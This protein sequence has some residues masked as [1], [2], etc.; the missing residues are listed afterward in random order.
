MSRLRHIDL[1]EFGISILLAAAVLFTAAMVML[2]RNV[3]QLSESYGWVE[4]SNDILQGIS[5]VELSIAGVEMTVRGY[6][7]TSNDM[8][9]RMHRLNHTKLLRVTKT[10]GDLVA[11]EP[12]LQPDF[13]TLRG[14]VDQHEALYSSLIALGPGHQAAVAEAI[15]NAIKRH[16]RRVVAAML[17]QMRARAQGVLVRRQREAEQ[18]AKATYRQAIAIAALAFLAGTLGF[19]MTLFGRRS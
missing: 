10:L 4:K 19:A 2:S 17:N 12:D 5:S 18:R 13:A 14:L 16:D 15:T 1:R 6:A 8:F 11:S 7:L 9:I 3:S